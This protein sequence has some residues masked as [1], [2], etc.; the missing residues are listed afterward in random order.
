VRVFEYLPFLQDPNVALCVA[1]AGVLA[2]YL[3][4]LRPGL[5]LPG[6]IG[7][8]A[9]MVALAGQPVPWSSIALACTGV[10]A[11]ARSAFAL[12]WWA[13][14]IAG[15]LLLETAFQGIPGVNVLLSTAIA[16]IIGVLSTALLRLA[17]I[18]RRNKTLRYCGV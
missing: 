17:V 12:R 9:L 11:I 3:E 10:A 5:V 1:A 15:V 8:G 18:A 13:W 14:T 2:I 4:F 7:G 6:V 16:V